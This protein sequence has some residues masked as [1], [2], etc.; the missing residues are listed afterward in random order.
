MGC[1][2][3]R[4][5]YTKLE[6]QDHAKEQPD[7]P[8]VSHR[9][10]LVRIWSALLATERQPALGWS[11][12]AV[13]RHA[14]TS[15]RHLGQGAKKEPGSNCQDKGGACRWWEVNVNP[16][17]LAGPVTCS[18]RGCWVPVML[19]PILRLPLGRPPAA[20]P[21]APPHGSG[22][23]FDSWAATLLPRDAEATVV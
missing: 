2:G 11:A 5:A 1:G 18:A 23:S 6:S 7:C 20:L 19:S 10:V 15:C 13:S 22:S 3:G 12:A 9:N 8:C 17:H 16:G 4:R 14:A 21:H